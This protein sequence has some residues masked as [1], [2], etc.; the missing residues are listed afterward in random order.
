MIKMRRSFFAIGSF[1]LLSMHAVAS[2][3]DW[4]LNGPGTTNVS[5]SGDQTITLSYALDPAGFST[6]T[7]TAS[8]AVTAPGDYQ[9][10][11]QYSGSHA[12][13]DVR[14]FLEVLGSND[15]LYRAGPANCCSAPSG[16]FNASGSYLFE[17]VQLGDVIGFSFGG[18]NYDYNNFLN[19][20][21]VLTTTE[22]PVPAVGWM[23]GLVLLGLA[24]IG[25]TR[26]FEG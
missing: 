4:V 1:L 19:G 2:P 3:L 17:N 23:F 14:V 5:P 9:I 21:L 13:Y 15:V 18:S 24:S 11:W 22:V 6:R 26:K 25:R 8:S 12:W 10:D 20:E 16:S 7:W